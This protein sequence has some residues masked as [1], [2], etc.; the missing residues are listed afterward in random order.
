MIR[1]YVQWSMNKTQQFSW[2]TFF[3]IYCPKI[4]TILYP[5][6]RNLTTGVTITK[7]ESIVLMLTVFTI[8]FPLVIMMKKNLKNL[9]KK[10]HWSSSRHVFTNFPNTNLQFFSDKYYVI[11]VLIFSNAQNWDFF[12]MI[13]FSFST[14]KYLVNKFVD[15]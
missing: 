13:L 1:C 14:E 8:E 4:Y 9:S 11:F 5:S 15:S 2:I 3:L 7:R 6:V 12:S 10:C